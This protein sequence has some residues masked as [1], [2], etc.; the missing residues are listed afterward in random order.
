MI[1]S[2]KANPL[3]QVVGQLTNSETRTSHVLG[4]AACRSGDGATY[5]T[6]ALARTLASRTHDNVLEAGISDLACLIGRSTPAMLDA[7]SAT[8]PDNL[9]RLTCSGGVAPAHHS[10]PAGIKSVADALGGKFRFLVLDCGTVSVSGSLWPAAQIVDDLLL[11]V[12]AGET[13]RSQITYAQRL[14][15][16]SGVH[17]A[18][19]ILNKRTYPLPQQIYRLL[20]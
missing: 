5:T 14:I 8:S 10:A 9:F 19:C 2:P 17:L 11:V 12:A 13:K 3:A 4:I 16:R 15:A 6:G 18:G 20:G 7:C 1:E